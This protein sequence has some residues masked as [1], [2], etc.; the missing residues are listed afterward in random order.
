[1]IPKKRITDLAQASRGS[2]SGN[3]QQSE[4]R[5]NLL[6]NATGQIHHNLVETGK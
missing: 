2:A 6:V 1:M 3:V 5:C 4:M